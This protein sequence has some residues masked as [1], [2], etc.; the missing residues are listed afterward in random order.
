MKTATY[1]LAILML[2]AAAAVAGADQYDDNAG[3]T[4]HRFRRQEE[5]FVRQDWERH[6]D[7]VD[8]APATAI[9][10]PEI[11]AGSAIAALVLLGGALIVL[12]GR[13]RTRPNS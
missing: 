5:N 6:R 2:T 10:A 11:S 3:N 12:R 1:G 13:Y 9:P 4:D 8:S 7:R